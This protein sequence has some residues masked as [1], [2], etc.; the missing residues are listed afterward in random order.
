MTEMVWP[1]GQFCQMEITLRYLFMWHGEI[2]IVHYWGAFLCFF[3][4]NF[5]PV[6]LPFCRLSVLGTGLEHG[7]THG[8]CGNELKKKKKHMKKI[9]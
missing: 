9:S 4:V 1:V 2:E 7:Q 5:V 3:V 6:L 8:I